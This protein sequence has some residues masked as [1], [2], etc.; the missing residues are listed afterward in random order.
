MELGLVIYTDGACHVT[1]RIGGIGVVFTKDNKLI[2][3][4]NKQFTNVTNNQMELLAV[5]YA[6]SAIKDTDSVTIYSDS[7]YVLGCITKGWKRKKNV[8]LWHKFDK[9][10]KLALNKCPNI[11]FEWVKGHNDSIFNNMADK[12]AVEAS[13]FI[14]QMKKLQKS[15]IED[16]KI[17]VEN[18]IIMNLMI[19]YKLQ[20]TTIKKISI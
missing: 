1:T 17:Q 19:L 16:L 14:C 9:V 8:K 5:M 4:Y 20:F 13:N 12:L 18:G 11:K 15:L 7:Q 10:Y 2:S 6:L 3:L